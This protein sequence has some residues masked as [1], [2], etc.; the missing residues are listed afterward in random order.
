MPSSLTSTS[1]LCSTAAGRLAQLT[2]AS[3]GLTTWLAAC[4]GDDTVPTDAS[5]APDAALDAGAL[6]A[7]PPP[8]PRADYG[9]RGAFPVGNRRVV[10]DDG[11]GSRALPV[12]LW[13]PA[14]EAARTVSET[15]VP[16]ADF[17]RGTP[18]EARMTE[19]V[20]ASDPACL[21]A[22]T[23][24]APAPAAATRTAPWPL[25]VFSHCHVCTRFDVAEVAERLA[26]HGIVVAAPDHEGNTLWD[27]EAGTAAEL[28]SD[29]L[30]VRVRDVRRVLDRLLEAGATEVP[31]DLRGRLDP[32]RAGVMGHSFGG[33]TTGA[34]VAEEPRFIAAL[35][36]AAPISFLT[37]TRPS[38]VETPFLLL[39]ARED[40]SIM[41]AGNT[42][43]RNDFRRLAGPAWLVEVDDAGHWSFS[44]I[45]G[46]GGTNFLAGCGAG[47]RQ[48]APG[49]TFDYLDNAAARDLA[50]DVAAAF[51]A[52]HLLDDPGG[53]TALERL[54]LPAHVT[55]R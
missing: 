36:I 33:L 54:P 26:S 30:A 39:L 40:N 11:S 37:G 53:A 8:E 50:A 28:G 44:D 48:T 22:Q 38:S 41:E 6:D 29:F 45:A 34:V 49:E 24:S 21:R 5:T 20:A 16:L 27:F 1:R 9:V 55:R 7:G 25:V 23:A 13:Y 35:S 43:I 12:E 46:L 32:A 47:T 52:V 42:V 31:E 4:G 3:L 18:H 51:F 14:A 15:G 2:V 17:E 19:L 10:M